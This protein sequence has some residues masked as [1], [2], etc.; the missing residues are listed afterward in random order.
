MK[1]SKLAE[2]QRRFQFSLKELEKEEAERGN[3]G[4]IVDKKN[5]AEGLHAP[6]AL[7]TNTPGVQVQRFNASHCESLTNPGPMSSDHGMI[8]SIAHRTRSQLQ[9]R[10]RSNLPQIDSVADASA[11]TQHP[12]MKWQCGGKRPS[13]WRSV[14]DEAIHKKSRS[15]T[16]KGRCGPPK[17]ITPILTPTTP[18]PI[19]SQTIRCKSTPN[20]RNCPQ[21]NACTTNG[22]ITPKP[23][24]PKTPKPH[25][26]K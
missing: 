21:Q 12:T 15:C 13:T 10:E 25:D 3:R 24:N 26:L 6:H 20:G 9:K 11:Q 7:L 17:K 4:G 8:D 14:A 22:Q 5:P 16:P 18:T 2:L 19:P 1:E 23:Q